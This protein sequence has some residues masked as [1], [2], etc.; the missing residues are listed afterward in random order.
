MIKKTIYKVILAD[1]KIKKCYSKGE[2]LLK[3]TV[4]NELNRD[5]PETFDKVEKVIRQRLSKGYFNNYP[6]WAI[7]KETEIKIC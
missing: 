2:A 1:G 7:S 4:Q 3:A 5:Y 6:Y